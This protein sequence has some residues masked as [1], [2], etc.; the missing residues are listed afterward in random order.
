MDIF[1]IDTEEC[2]K[3]RIAVGIIVKAFHKARFWIVRTQSGSDK[4]VDVILE[5]IEYD[6]TIRQKT[7]NCQ[8][9]GRSNIKKLFKNESIS[10][11]LDVKT[12]NQAIVSNSLFLLL[13]VNLKNEDIYYCKLNGYGDLSYNKSSVNIRVP[14]KNKFPDNEFGLRELFNNPF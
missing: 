1:K 4:G 7:A 12:Y 13:V 3:E 5:M 8:V 10:I 11:P 14:L 2:K 9:K 6:N